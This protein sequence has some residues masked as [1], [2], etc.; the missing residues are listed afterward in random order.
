MSYTMTPEDILEVRIDQARSLAVMLYGESGDEFRGMSDEHQ[1][2]V[3]WLLSDLLGEIQ[4]AWKT[5]S[6][7]RRKKA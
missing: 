1:S 4:K 2:N 7:E 6:E 5:Y 3:C